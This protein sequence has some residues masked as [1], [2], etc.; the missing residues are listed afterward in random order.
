[1]TYRGNQV[2]HSLRNREAS[3]SP[4]TFIR[5]SLMGEPWTG[6]IQVTLTFEDR[7]YGWKGSDP[8]SL[9][10]LIKVVRYEVSGLDETSRQTLSDSSGSP[11]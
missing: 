8:S 6:P 2:A 11:P 7:N 10:N 5:I 1:M 9:L 3:T 4:L